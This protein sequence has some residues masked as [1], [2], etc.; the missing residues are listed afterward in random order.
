MCAWHEESVMLHRVHVRYSPTTIVHVWDPAG[1]QRQRR[2]HSTLAEL[3]T[4]AD[5]QS[6]V[7]KVLM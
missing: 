3:S 4:N 6:N 1:E 5:V 7:A 2:L